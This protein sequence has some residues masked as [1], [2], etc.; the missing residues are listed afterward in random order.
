MYRVNLED[1]EGPLDLLLFFIRRDELD[2]FNI[3]IA[4]IADEYL[5]HV[6][7]MQRVDLDNVGEFLYMAAMLINIKARMLLPKPELDEEGEPIDPRRELV[8]RLLE[9]VRYKEGSHQI[10]ALKQNRERHATRGLAGFER[11]EAEDDESVE[12]RATMFDLVSAMRRLLATAPDEVVH[13]LDRESYSID[14]QAE[15]LLE[16]LEVRGR[17]SFSAIMAGRS[18]AFIIAAF[19]AALELAR[20]GEVD[21]F[22]DS[23][24]IDFALDVQH[25]HSAAA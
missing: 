3:P 10:A 20:R 25:R 6:R 21:I 22:V 13:S 8:E 11:A 12:I 5:E 7:L 17:C 4:S 15:F 16:T 18:R 24:P 9:Y 23:S 2:I 19:L 1:F 14:E